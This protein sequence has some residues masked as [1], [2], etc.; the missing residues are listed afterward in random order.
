VVKFEKSTC[1]CFEQLFH[2]VAVAGTVIAQ[3][4]S[5]QQNLE[6]RIQERGIVEQE[7]HLGQKFGFT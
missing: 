7:S 1:Y 2:F 5:G 3:A 6:G 4:A